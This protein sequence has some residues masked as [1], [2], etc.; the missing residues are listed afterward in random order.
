[1]P[2]ATCH[3]GASWPGT[4]RCHCSGC[5]QTFSAITAFDRHRVDGRCQDPHIRD[6]EY[7]EAAQVWRSPGQVPTG[8]W[9]ER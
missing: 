8:T 9:G 5:H 4:A 1:M 7:D 3:C 6:L 2:N